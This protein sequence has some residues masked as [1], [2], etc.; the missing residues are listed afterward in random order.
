[1]R[2]FHHCLGRHFPVA[3]LIAGLSEVQAAPPGLRSAVR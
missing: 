3:E 1:V 2:E